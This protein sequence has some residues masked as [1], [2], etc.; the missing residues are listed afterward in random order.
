[1]EDWSDLRCVYCGGSSLRI[2]TDFAGEGIQRAAIVCNAC[3][4][5]NDV[6]DTV[7]FMGGFDSEDFMGLIEIVA[8]GEMNQS[9]IDVA[10]SRHL[11]ALL[12][13]FHAS[14]EKGEFVRTHPEDL[15][16]APWFADH[17]Y[18]EWLQA[19]SMLHG[20]DLAGK[21]VLNVGAGFG[22]DSV[23]LVDAGALVTCLD[24]SPLMVALGH[25]GLPQ[26]RWI[27]GFSHA[28]P[29]Q[30]DSFDIVC[31]NAALHHMRSTPIALREMLR[32]LKPGGFMYTAGDP[33]RSDSSSEE[34][35][36][37]VFNRHEG[38]LSGVNEGIIRFG[39]FYDTIAPYAAYI[40][41][42]MIASA[43]DPSKLAGTTPVGDGTF[44]DRWVPCWQQ[45]IDVLREQDG[46]GICL[47]VTKREAFPIP[48][49]T[50]EPSVLPAG[51][52]SLWVKDPET[53]FSHLMAWAP[54]RLV[55]LPFPG[56][57]Q[58]WFSL[59][60]GWMAPEA[61]FD[62]RR[63]FHRARWLARAP[64]AQTLSFS[65]R[66]VTGS[67]NMAV[68]INGLPVTARPIN[69]A[70]SRIEVPLPLDAR[71]LPLLIELRITGFSSEAG[72]DE[73]CFEVRDR[74][75]AG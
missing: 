44:T 9:P 27:G 18:H 15:V 46:A 66:T 16:R 65:A 40:D 34:L 36:F 31:S 42:A 58:D 17:R 64:N 52:L 49:E 28:L 24:Y 69:P 8:T 63:G 54:D 20:R 74:Q 56:E 12:A 21:K 72:F 33:T 23:P 13:E 4:G 1:M 73:K 53:A 38:V 32:V 57:R 29:F 30:D 61:P 70:W 14:R 47:A 67:S 60:N 50:L 43:P 5:S 71:Q 7:P 26:A 11:H 25:K 3:G 39:D 62:S 41:F 55:D 35:E 59:L 45:N 68:M 6:I 10:F 2:A 48:A 19:N 22:F 37:Q 51:D 75:F